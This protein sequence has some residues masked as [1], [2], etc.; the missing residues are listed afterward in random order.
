MSKESRARL[1]FESQKH[2]SHQSRLKPK[3]VHRPNQFRPKYIITNEHNYKTHYRFCYNFLVNNNIWLN[4]FVII[5][6]R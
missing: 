4:F 6:I 3:T 5:V 1:I 2:T